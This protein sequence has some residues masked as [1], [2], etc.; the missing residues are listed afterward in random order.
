MIVLVGIKA[1]DSVFL[2]KALLVK[3]LKDLLL[4]WDLIV[5][6]DQSLVHADW[7][8]ALEPGVLPDLFY[9]QAF[10]WVSCQDLLQ[11]VCGRLADEAWYLKFT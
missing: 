7:L 1:S 4:V 10:L 6:N 5:A 11:E 3:H 2:L 8:V 9:F